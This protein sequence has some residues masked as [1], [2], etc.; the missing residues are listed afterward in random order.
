MQTPPSLFHWRQLKH[1][2]T[3]NCFSAEVAQ[4]E[5]KAWTPKHYKC[6]TTQSGNLTP[7]QTLSAACSLPTVTNR[8]EYLTH[9]V[10]ASLCMYMWER[11]EVGEHIYADCC[12]RDRLNNSAGGPS[13]C[14]ALLSGPAHFFPPRLLT[15]QL[16][17]D[18]AGT[19]VSET[20][21]A[22]LPEVRVQADRPALLWPIGRET[23]V[24]VFTSCCPSKLAW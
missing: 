24:L 12:D 15:S 14:G 19:H 1:S 10:C 2:L 3:V 7:L 6:K 16:E 11:S 20:L 13:K 18:T 5:N 9:R 8:D 4:T 22:L 23:V 17:S 21:R